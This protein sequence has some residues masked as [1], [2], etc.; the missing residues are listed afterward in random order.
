MYVGV[1]LTLV[2]SMVLMVSPPDV[3]WETQPFDPDSKIITDACDTEL[4][5]SQC[6]PKLPAGFNF[7]KNFKIDGQ[8]GAKDKIEYSYVLTN[9]TQYLINLCAKTGNADGIVMTLYDGNRN[10][11][12]ASKA[13]EQY[14]TA[15]S[16][17]CNATGIYYI[18]YTFDGSASFCAGSTLSFKR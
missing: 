12:V 3:S 8:G 4:L 6:I 15:M 1:S 11:M 18:Q 14:V 5:C 9:G 17:T 7:I 10:R 2:L 13:G 16:F